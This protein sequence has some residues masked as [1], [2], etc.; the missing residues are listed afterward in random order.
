MRNTKDGTP[1][2]GD[3][4]YRVCH[5]KGKTVLVQTGCSTYMVGLCLRNGCGDDKPSCFD[6]YQDENC[7]DT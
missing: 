7:E 5:Q 4:K 1:E 6:L 3:R 2:S